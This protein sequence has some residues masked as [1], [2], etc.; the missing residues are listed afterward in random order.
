[1]QFETQRLILRNWHPTE[2]ARHAMDI[3]GD[4]RVMAWMAPASKDISLRQ[5]QSR[6]QQYI[7]HNRRAE[8]GTR[9]WAVVQKDIGRVIGHVALT[10]LPDLAEVRKNHVVEEIPDGLSTQYVEITC[11]FRPASWGFGY[12][13][14]AAHRII[15]YGFNELKLPCLLGITPPENSR[16]I[17]LM[18]RLGME[19][20]GPTTR[21]YR[22]ELLSL[23]RLDADVYTTD[24]DVE[25]K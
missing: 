10:L 2:D 5:V 17:A 11:Q 1:M 14:E 25:T 22:G 6:L 24:S 3:F 9:S 8:L 13:T 12:A 20:D 18:K 19:Y 23:H 21:F 15:Q 7:E 4:A 16:S